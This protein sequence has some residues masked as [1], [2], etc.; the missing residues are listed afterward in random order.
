[1]KNLVKTIAVAVLMLCAAAASAQNYGRYEV[2]KDRV[3][4]NG[5]ELRQAEARWFNEIG[6]AHV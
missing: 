4:F 5:V 2:R 3:Y 1:M 6:R